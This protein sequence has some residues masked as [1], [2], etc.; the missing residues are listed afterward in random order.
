MELPVQLEP[1]AVVN[2]AVQMFVDI[3]KGRASRNAFPGG[4]RR[5]PVLPDLMQPL[6]LAF[7]LVRVREHERD[8]DELQP[9]AELGQRPVSVYSA[10]RFCSLHHGGRPHGGAYGFL[11]DNNRHL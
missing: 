8:V 4:I 1:V 11:S 10:F 2:K 3:F 7:R 9:L 5:K 6:D